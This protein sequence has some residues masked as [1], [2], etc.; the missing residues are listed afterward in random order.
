MRPVLLLSALL[1]VGGARAADGGQAAANDVD[2]GGVGDE[3]TRTVREQFAYAD[4]GVRWAKLH[5]SYGRGLSAV[6]F[7]SKTNEI[8]KELGLSH[9]RL[10]APTEREYFEVRAVYGL[11]SAKDPVMLESIGADFASLPEG[12]FVREVFPGGPAEQ[13]GLR[14]GD[15]IE[16]ADGAPF[17]SLGSLRG[18]A[19]VAVQF[20]V[21]RQRGAPL[22]SLSITP[23]LV[24]IKAEWLEAV[25]RSVRLMP[26]DGKSIGYIRVFSC[27]GEDVEKGVRWALLVGPL[28]TADALLLDFRDGWGGCNPSMANHFNPILPA[29]TTISRDGSVDVRETA[30]RKP[31]VIL[32]NEGTRSGKEL[33]TFILQRGGVARVVGKT[34]A[35]A[36][37]TGR[38]FTLSDG[39]LFLL[40]VQD[41]AFDGVRLEGRGVIPDIVV[42]NSLQYAQGADPQLQRALEVAALLGRRIKPPVV[43]KKPPAK[44]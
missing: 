22:A 11:A 17:N 25:S 23:L 4:A 2:Y 42:E 7:P 30:W 13:A 43:P 19:G 14:R 1:L 38:V 21:A 27:S 18:K 31:V 12:T 36:V 3:V 35:G 10:Y 34:T 28:K 41:G 15:R 5:E 16:S 44:P 37:V 8:L 9:T 20:K 26:L 33:L 40:A 6:E 24:D 29:S 39:S 32:V